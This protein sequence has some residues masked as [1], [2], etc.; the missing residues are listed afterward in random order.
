MRSADEKVTKFRS[1]RARHGGP[2]GMCEAVAVRSASLEH[3]SDLPRSSLSPVE[4]ILAPRPGCQKVP[5]TLRLTLVASR[6]DHARGR[7]TQPDIFFFPRRTC[8]THSRKR[9][10]PASAT[11]PQ[12][13]AARASVNVTLASQPEI[14]RS[15]LPA[16]RKCPFGAK[17]LHL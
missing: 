2:E 8:F 14:Y 16:L 5:K 3:Y 11:Q 1:S 13:D 12:R 4:G 7:F 10:A 17:K 15:Q 9:R 6:S